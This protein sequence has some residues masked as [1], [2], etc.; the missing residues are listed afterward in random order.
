MP[1]AGLEPA[2]L[3]AQDPKSCVAANYTTS[4][5]NLVVHAGRITFHPGSRWFRLPLPR[6]RA[7][8]RV[9]FFLAEQA[10]LRGEN[11]HGVGIGDSYWKRLESSCARIDA[12]GV[13][14]GSRWLSAALEPLAK[15]RSDTTGSSDAW[16]LPSPPHATR[17]SLVSS[18]RGGEGAR[19]AGEGSFRTLEFSDLRHIRCCRSWV[20]G[21][22]FSETPLTRPLAT[23]SPA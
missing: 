12:G 20:G 10:C 4:A 13:A 22:G 6:E 18:H 19:R 1:R 9:W 14:E 5:A 17:V 2:R 3:A 8:V 16:N 21:T 7:G 11:A 23:L 15:G